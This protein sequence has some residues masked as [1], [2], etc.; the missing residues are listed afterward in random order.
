MSSS[1]SHYKDISTIQALW[2]PHETNSIKEFSMI[3]T[4]KQVQEFLLKQPSYQIHR[5]V[6][7][8]PVVKPIVASRPNQHWQMDLISMANPTMVHGMTYCL[9]IIDIFSKKAWAVPL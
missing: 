7:R 2:V 8:H 4:K 9:T 1:L 5:R 6:R 3:F